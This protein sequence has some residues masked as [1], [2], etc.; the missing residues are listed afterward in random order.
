MISWN[1][2]VI[3]LCGLLSAFLVWKEI[4]RKNRSRLLWRIIASLIM[5]ISF[6]CIIIPI[7]I[8]KKAGVLLHEA[9][10]ISEGFNND[11]VNSFR[12]HGGSGLPIFSFNNNI[13]TSFKPGNSAKLLSAIN[14]KEFTAVHLFGFGLNDDELQL[15]RGVPVIFHSSPLPGGIQSFSTNGNLQQ[16]EKLQVQGSYNNTSSKKIKIILSAFD[17]SLDS[18]FIPA[19]TKTTFN[20][21]ATPA[22]RGKAV[23]TMIILS[24]NDII[25]KEKFPVEVT[26]SKHLKI[27]MLGGYPGFENKF[28]KNWLAD[29]GHIVAVRTGISKNKYDQQFLNGGS[30]SLQHISPDLLSAYDMVITDASAF[31]SLN[32]NEQQNIFSFIREGK[33][34]IVQSDTLIRSPAITAIF[35]PLQSGDSTLKPL[36]ILFP[37][38]TAAVIETERYISFRGADDI[39]PL[40]TGKQQNNIAVT[41]LFG[42]GKLTITGLTNSYNWMLASSR[43]HYDY[44]WSSLINASIKNLPAT[45][46]WSFS[47]RFPVQDQALGVNYQTNNN[48]LPRVTIGSSPL[49]L[50]QNIY[51]PLKWQGNYWPVKP[52]WQPVFGNNGAASWIHIYSNDEWIAARAAEKTNNTMKF[53]AQQR[54]QNE[55][56]I[57]NRIISVMIPPVI[58]F[59]LFL[60][61]SA[62]LWFE[63]KYE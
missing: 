5:I 55:S 2:L 25:Q 51:L 1:Y 11:S 20:L 17:N 30:G 47:S 59:L 24:G 26:A 10:V 62:F 22:H 15:L 52:G 37:D 56:Q 9:I 41:A 34:M 54:R 12:K 21:S 23:Y 7:H 31:N 14:K 33:G 49:A 57:E 53:I 35:K 8:N 29:K 32:N 13:N 6:V 3:I 38:S 39:V 46:S 44:Y 36:S 48:T 58:F 43:D 18:I 40:V 27:L 45:E 42:K 4:T 60:F 28:L 61:S 50:S 16:G 19:N 63:K